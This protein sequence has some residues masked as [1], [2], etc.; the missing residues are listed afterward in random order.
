MSYTW[1]NFFA[2]N[3]QLPYVQLC[4]GFAFPSSMRYKLYNQFLNY[5]VYS[6]NWLATMLSLSGHYSTTSCPLLCHNYAINCYIYM[7]HY[8]AT[9]L[10]LLYNQMT[11]N[12][13]LLIHYPYK[14]WISLVGTPFFKPKSFQ[15]NMICNY[16]A[17]IIFKS[18]NGNYQL[19]QFIN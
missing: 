8:E 13:I 7:C 9:I 1:N 3:V 5:E 10:A 15:L 12:K 11:I 17:I 18:N 6:C 14:V 19:S 4:H 16:V 2:T